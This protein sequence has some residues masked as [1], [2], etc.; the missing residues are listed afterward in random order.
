MLEFQ[1]DNNPVKMLPEVESKK[2]GAALRK[3]PNSINSPQKIDNGEVSRLP[4]ADFLREAARWSNAGYI[5][6]QR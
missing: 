2:L 6:S 4:G 5:P 3:V 1:E